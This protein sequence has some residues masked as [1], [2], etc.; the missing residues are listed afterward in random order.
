ML[1]SIDVALPVVTADDTVH[2]KSIGTDSDGFSTFWSN[3]CE[4][5]GE[6]PS[7]G[8]MSGRIAPCLSQ[9]LV[10]LRSNRRLAIEGKW[11]HAL[12]VILGHLVS[13]DNGLGRVSSVK[14]G[15]GYC[16][17]T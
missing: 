5:E 13:T 9:V 2:G 11:A 7:T 15:S 12:E 14:N 1:T 3:G 6:H 10:F 8:R 17:Q 16:A 4:H